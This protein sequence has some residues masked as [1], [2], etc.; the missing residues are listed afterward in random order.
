MAST[1]SIGDVIEIP[2]SA[3]RAYAQYTHEHPDYG[4]L[5]RV[6]PGLF[7]EAPDDLPALVAEEE[8]FY[9]FY[10]LAAGLRERLVR[11]VA[12]LPVPDHSKAFPLLRSGGLPGE[13]RYVWDGNRE[14]RVRRPKPEHNLLSFA[15]IVSHPQLV[16]WIESGWRPE[17]ESW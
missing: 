17:A 1:P 4:E 16:E 14:V 5:L 3:G 13:P 2:T 7:D 6:L 9:T 15:E 11:V 12:H 8:Q 10:P